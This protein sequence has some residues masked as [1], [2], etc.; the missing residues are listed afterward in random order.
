MP[1]PSGC[2][3]AP[4]R[5]GHGE[6]WAHHGELFQGQIEEPPG[7]RRRCLVTLP[8]Y[9]LVSSACFMPDESGT[10]RVQPP[11][12]RKARRVV[13]LIL[14]RAGAS[15]VGGT[16]A[17]L[18]NITEGKGYGSSTADCVAA[19]QAAAQVV[20]LDLPPQTLAEV[21]VQ[22]EVASDNVMFRQAVL[23]AQREAVVL[24]DYARL[25][26]AIEVLGV[27]TDPRG[28]VDTLVYPPAEYSPQQIQRFHVLV[29][30]LRRAIRTEDV[31]LLGTVATA[32]A[33]INESFLA[34][35]MFDELSRLIRCASGLG[36]AV[37]HSGTVV[38]LL[39]D[40]RDP[41]LESR[42]EFLL[43][44]LEALGVPRVLRFRTCRA[45]PVL[46]AIELS[47]AAASPAPPAALAAAAPGH[48]RRAL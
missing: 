26:P 12:K 47:S 6:S 4:R 32:S 18:N 8:C 10:V 2:N 28:F 7:R 30:A 48:V 5:P 9:G 45:H 43:T 29:A 44:K 23:F 19:A 35:P 20:G 46:S 41:R 42:V 16:L 13:E 15:H 22:A 33:V 21:V 31:A 27:D 40:P 1:K 17:L 14:A 38:S 25:F 24:E 36:V 39:L 3:G 34:K 37:A 11:H